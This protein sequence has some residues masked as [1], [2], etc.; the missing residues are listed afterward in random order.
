M[1]DDELCS[2]M[3]KLSLS[4]ESYTRAYLAVVR[5]LIMKTA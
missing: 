5:E 2:H 4:V 1:T 3:M